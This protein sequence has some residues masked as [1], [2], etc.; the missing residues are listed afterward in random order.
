[1]NS[2]TFQEI[3]EEA[4]YHTQSYSG[5]GMYGKRC[6]AITTDNSIG[7]VMGNIFQV[8]YDELDEGDVEDFADTL[9]GMQQDHMGKS[10][11][12]YY[13]PNIE[14]TQDEDS[15]QDYDF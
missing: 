7:T 10:S 6:I 11:M 14:Y 1:M 5:R 2:N 9:S 3:L 15:D 13:F 8:A 4:G 12:V